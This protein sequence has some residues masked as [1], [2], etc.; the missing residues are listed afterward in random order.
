MRGLA[1]LLL[2]VLVSSTSSSSSSSSD[3]PITPDSS[4]RSFLVSFSAPLSV[5]VSGLEPGAEY[6]AVAAWPASRPALVSLSL[7]SPE[8]V[9]SRS[10][11]NTEKLV[12]SPLGHSATLLVSATDEAVF[13]RASSHSRSSHV[14]LLLSV[15][16]R[17]MGLSLQSWLVVAACLVSVAAA[18]LLASKVKL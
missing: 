15:R 13:S 1:F 9:S 14:S 18:A 8:H 7:L 5:A 4:P 17:R 2:L 10:L 3:A 11:L 6:E 16:Q 12:F